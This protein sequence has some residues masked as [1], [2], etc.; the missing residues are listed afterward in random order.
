[1]SADF[2]RQFLDMEGS[3]PRQEG[4]GLGGNAGLAERSRTA[5]GLCPLR[6][7]PLQLQG[8]KGSVC[9]GKKYSYCVQEA[10]LSMG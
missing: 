5:L 7:S 3:H 6:F 4:A 10:S 2:N 9:L 1:M 8:L